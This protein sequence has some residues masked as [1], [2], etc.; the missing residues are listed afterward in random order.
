MSEV[1][2]VSIKREEQRLVTS[3]LRAIGEPE[4]ALRLADASLLAEGESLLHCLAG[5]VRS[6]ERRLRDGD[7]VAYGY[8]LLKVRGTPGGNLEILERSPNGRDFDPGATLTLS[9]WRD[10]HRTCTQAG[11]DFKPPRPDTL[12]AVAPGVMDGDPVEGVRYPSP[13]HMSGWWFFTDRYDGDI[14]KVK[15]EHLYHVTAA[16]PDLA[17]FLALPPGFR[18]SQKAGSKVWLD[19]VVAA[20]P[21]D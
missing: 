19:P 15:T 9:Y 2:K 10:Q 13:A 21:A 12:V 3:G 17:A 5:Y 16:R 14:N 7:T 11:V 1:S 4:I 6:G 18:F 20:E 8:W